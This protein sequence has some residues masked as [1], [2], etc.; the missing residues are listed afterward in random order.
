VITNI[1]MQVETA[2]QVEIVKSIETAESVIP[3]ES[4]ESVIPVESDE[5]VV[6]VESVEPDEPVNLDEP[7]VSVEPA[8]TIETAELQAE[9]SES[10]KD[11]LR[12]EIEIQMREQIE[13][14]M[15][16]KMN[17]KSKNEEEMF[18]I[19]QQIKEL[20]EE[21]KNH[22]NNINSFVSERNALDAKINNSNLIINNLN[23]QIKN[24]NSVFSQK[25]V[26]ITGVT[27][28]NSDTDTKSKVEETIVSASEAEAPTQVM[29]TRVIAS[30]SGEISRTGLGKVKNNL[31]TNYG[32]SNI[33][34]SSDN[35]ILIRTDIDYITIV[36]VKT[37]NM[38]NLNINQYIGWYGRPLSDYLND[39]EEAVSSVYDVPELNIRECDDLILLIREKNKEVSEFEYKYYFVKYNMNHDI[40]NY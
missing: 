25:F 33:I 5:P 29:N 34:K 30:F 38:Y 15:R 21:V 2:N 17:Q 1:E 6:S 39:I 14:E 10:L 23:E 8:K 36:A 35:Y 13:T 9:I 7:V 22:E 37:S 3:V 4:V 32:R 18:Q 20:Q 19:L 24:L 26:N 40:F 12:K 27:F 11:R 28:V 16:E 31:N